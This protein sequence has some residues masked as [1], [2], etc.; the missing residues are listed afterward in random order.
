MMPEN[1]QTIDWKNEGIQ[2]E[3]INGNIYRLIQFYEMP[4]A[5]LHQRIKN[6]GIKLLD[7]IPNK[8]YIASI[9]KNISKTKL[10]ALNIRSI[11]KIENKWKQ[12]EDVKYQTFGDW[13]L[14]RGLVDLS[15]R[16]YKNISKDNIVRKF[17]RQGIKILKAPDF[18]H[19][20][21]IRVPHSQ[22][23]EIIEL[24]Y[25]SYVSQV[26]D[27]GTP[28]DD[29]GRGLHR[30]NMID[31]HFPTGRHYTGEGIKILVRDDGD[32]G[33]HIDFH[34]RLNQNN[35]D[36]TGTHG[37]GVAGLAG[38]AGNLN[39]RYQGMATGSEVYVRQ[40][41][42]DF[43]DETM[44]LHLNEGILLTNSSYSNGCNAGYTEITETVDQQI[45]QNPTLLHIFSGGNSN[46]QEC[47]Y[48]AGN[49]W[50]NITGG[51]KQGK[52]VI[53]TANL[54]AD[55]SLVNSSS[56]GP[57]DDG[58]IKPDIAANGAN[59]MSTDPDNTYDPFGGTSAA[60]PCVMG[61]SAQLYQAYQELNGGD[62]PESSLIKATLL[63][64]ANDL[65]NE[66]PDFKFGWGHLNAFRAVKLLEDE[67]YFDGM[68]DQGGLPQHTINIPA[69]TK[70][71]RFMLYWMDEASTPTSGIALVNDLNLTVEDP[72]MNTL[73]P[74][75][76]DP[77]PIPANL[78]TPAGNG[79]DNL[80]NM[81]Q[82]LINDPQEGDYVLSI[83]GLTVP[84]GAIKYYIVYEVISDN[85]IT[86]TYPNGGDG[87]V[88]GEIER[89]HWD[90]IGENGNFLVEYSSDNGATWNA[91]TTVSGSER[92]TD[93]NV[94]NLQ[95]G[96]VQVRV[97]RDG[98]SDTSDAN[99]SIGAVP[100][101]VNIA[102]ACPDY[103][104]VNWDLV[105][106]A[107]AYDLYKLG[108][109]YMDSI[110]TTTDLFFDVPITNPNDENWFAVRAVGDEN[111]V[112]RRTIAINHNAGLMNCMIDFD[113]ANNQMLSPTQGLT[114]A[115]DDYVQDVTMV[116]QNNGINDVAGVNLYYQL[117]NE[118]PVMET[119]TSNIG[120]FVDVTFTFATPFTVTTS[121]IHTVKSW[122]EFASDQVS[123]NDTLETSFTLSLASNPQVPDIVE[124]FESGTF[125][126]DNW[127][128]ANADGGTTWADATV[129]GSDG[130]ITTAAFMDNYVYNAP[131]QE[132][133]FISLPIDLT[134]ISS[135]ILSFDMAYAPYSNNFNDSMRVDIFVDCG[136]QYHST[137]YGA[138][139]LE[140]A[141]VPAP[142]QGFNSWEPDSP[143]EWRNEVIDLSAFIDQ[144][145]IVKF[146]NINGY[147]NSLYL[148]NIN[149]M[150]ASAAPEASL[151]SSAPEV[152][153]DVP[154]VFQNNSTGLGNDYTWDF[155]DGA[156]IAT[157]TGDG[158]FTITYSTPGT[159]TITLSATNANGTDMDTRQVEVIPPPAP[160]FTYTIDNDEVT[161]TN[162]STNSINYF[163]DMGNSTTSSD[164]NPIITYTTSGDYT[165]T[166]TSSSPLCGSVNYSETIT[167]VI[168]SLQEQELDIN[169]AIIPN[170]NNGL[171]NLSISDNTS[172]DLEVELIDLT[173][174]VLERRLVR[175]NQGTT[176]QQI[177]NNNLTASVY[178]V[179]IRNENSVKVLKVVVQ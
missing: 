101:N 66:G 96:Q 174:R 3:F 156:S 16:Y 10:K 63:N 7:Y 128:V 17:E 47:G 157:G 32:V 82:V 135:P 68:V 134:G 90:A 173:G 9:P 112:G 4:K 12:S 141:T 145:I 26:T 113:V 139:H 77:T 79:V 43:L 93:W 94:P 86:V 31:S 38:G 155:G 11:I 158:P 78:D 40:Y 117:D 36:F 88:P 111:F 41:V 123:F 30:T 22:V 146:I 73:L 114:F 179:K 91:I 57:A 115:C 89:I 84:N 121:G 29:L 6:A 52:N 171:F 37:D 102:Q 168:T 153:V 49:Q 99:L 2:G 69:S 95:T 74:W 131:D 21:Q 167:V 45:Q 132:D 122:V 175:S 130:N 164:E 1:I 42:A 35:T 150:N 23:N 39:P 61:T 165:V 15:V 33:P 104:R 154:V 55:A 143:N 176:V 108:E 19:I 166:L 147:G 67:R 13:A 124:T 83:E 110:G 169:A 118:P 106:G 20:V 8:A 144:V 129:V 27:P 34:G 119:Y 64:T 71:V 151:S 60:A 28:E 120:P 137:V 142:I 44:D 152:C 25:V 136:S 14:N 162:T 126:P 62:T 48:G 72:T 170:P 138:S 59:Q 161:F 172:R 109:K 54:N 148:D 116:F 107:T 92:M 98:V 125:P 46:N 133:E 70:Q 76:L 97:T 159:K 103:I 100:Q 5:A 140:L 53:A 65:G 127:S 58:R 178:F 50:G 105:A 163:W 51:H 80:N 56:R 18:M 177:G 87:F 85:D 75:V 160:S 24:P 149:F 81:E